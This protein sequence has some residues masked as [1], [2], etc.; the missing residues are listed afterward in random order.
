MTFLLDADDDVE[1]GDYLRSERGAW[2]RVHTARDVQ[3]RD[4]AARRRQRLTVTR[5]DTGDAAG[6]VLDRGDRV[7]HFVRHRRGSRR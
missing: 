2:Y 7:H 3:R 1:P 6:L 4:P 5:L